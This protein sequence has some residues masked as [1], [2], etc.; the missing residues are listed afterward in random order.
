MSS[1]KFTIAA[2]LFVGLVMVMAFQYVSMV[3]SYFQD[4]LG[5]GIAGAIVIYPDSYIDSAGK[6]LILHV[7]ISGNGDIIV[8]RV[9]VVGVETTYVS[10]IKV[11]SGGSTIKGNAVN[12]NGAVEAYIV[13]SLRGSY[14]PG[15]SYTVRVYTNSGVYSATIIAR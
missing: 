9:E 6:N 2:V 13:A 11:V 12:V 4:V 7:S 3:V 10:S 8:Q 15:T 1:G 14:I 5:R